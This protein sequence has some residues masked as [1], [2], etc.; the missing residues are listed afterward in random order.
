VDFTAHIWPGEDGWDEGEHEVVFT[1]VDEVGD[2]D[3]EITSTF[4]VS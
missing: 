4:D 2:K 1:V 3:M